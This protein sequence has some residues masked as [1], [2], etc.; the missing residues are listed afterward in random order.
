M[1]KCIFFHFLII[2]WAGVAGELHEMQ[3]R[4]VEDVLRSNYEGKLKNNISNINF[5]NKRH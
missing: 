5:I 2:W 4:D 1:P 3:M